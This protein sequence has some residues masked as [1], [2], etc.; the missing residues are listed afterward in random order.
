MSPSAHRGRI[1]AVVASGLLLA[2]AFAGPVGASNDPAFDLQWGLAKIG[3]P[4]AW[5]TTTGAGI[6]IGI[7]DS[8]I[9][10]AHEDL[11]GGKI[12]GATAC[13]DTRG[14]SRRC[15]GSGQDID[16]HGTHVAGI[17]AAV[18][19]NGRGIAGVAPDS[20]LLVARVFDGD[21]ASTGDILA[22]IKWAVDNGARVV[23]LSLGDILPVQGELG[24]GDDS[25]AEGIEYAWSRGAVAVLAAGNTNLLGFGS[26]NYGNANAVVVGATGRSDEISSYSSETGNAKWALVAPGGNGSRGGETAEI[27]STYWE[28]GGPNNL[29]GYLQGT[30]MAAPHVSGAL[31]LLMSRPGINNQRAVEILLAS[32]D[33]N[34]KCGP[35]S[36][37]CVGRLD[38]AKAIAMAGG[39]SPA[40]AP[41]APTTAPPPPPPSGSQTP[42][43]ARPAGRP[44]PTPPPANQPAAPE[45]PPAPILEDASTPTTAVEAEPDQ[46][47]TIGPGG[48]V[49]THT[50]ESSPTALLIGVGA[51]ALIG[52]AAWLVATQRKRRFSSAA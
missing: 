12:V 51:T 38:V 50:D 49:E 14:D 31:A 15:T 21:T 2:V 13:I 45:P 11:Q 23:N 36:D 17:A 25:F 32:A 3:A 40:S 20:Q 8:G 41:V 39:A 46:L 43:T 4:T 48:Q 9:H 34:V 44:G 29:Y 30:S 10:L 26:A 18:K 22:G 6:R 27:F 1:S 28:R 42:T 7:V 33:R 19:D 5:A 35:N 37:N 16:G 47:F 24:G 52:V